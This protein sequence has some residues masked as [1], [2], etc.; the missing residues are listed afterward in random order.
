MPTV[1][2]SQSDKREFEQRQPDDMTQAEFTAELLA[3]HARDNGEIVDVDAIVERIESRTASQVE[4]A[5]YRGVREALE[6][7]GVRPEGDD[8]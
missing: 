4:T 3:A 5:A 2:I 8:G 6:E 1:G 7:L